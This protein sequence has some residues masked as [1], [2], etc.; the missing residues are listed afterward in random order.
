MDINS[1]H[2]E[3]EIAA[4]MIKTEIIADEVKTENTT[5]EVKTEVAEDKVNVENAIKNVKIEL[6]ADTG[7]GFNCKYCNMTFAV[8]D[9]TVEQHM[10][11]HP[12]E[13]KPFTCVHCLKQFSK[14]AHLKR[15]K[16]IHT[17]EKS[18]ICSICDKGFLRLDHLQSH[19]L[20]HSDHRPFKCEDCNW[21]FARPTSLK[22]HMDK[23][24]SVLESIPKPAN[25]ERKPVPIR[26]KDDLVLVNFCLQQSLQLGHPVAQPT[27]SPTIKSKTNNKKVSTKMVEDSQETFVCA[28]CKS[29][30]TS[31]TRALQCIN[32]H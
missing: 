25:Q 26:S 23:H 19:K 13:K 9:K 31:Q 16:L 21:C 24:H 20:V 28:I 11:I 18:Y 14:F 15:H 22:L 27:S 1:G 5:V 12:Q 8:L 17:G 7:N 10:T 32:S 30:F 4:K 6:S 3:I 29:T 2:Q